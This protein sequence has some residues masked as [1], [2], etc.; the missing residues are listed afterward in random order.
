MVPIELLLAGQC[1]G[2][3][4]LPTSPNISRPVNK[5]HATLVWGLKPWQSVLQALCSSEPLSS[6][7]R[8]DADYEV[9]MGKQMEQIPHINGI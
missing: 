7:V 5:N 4:T 2:N 3:L 9:G 1:N 6:F 8:E